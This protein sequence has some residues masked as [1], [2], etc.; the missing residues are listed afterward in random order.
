LGTQESEKADAQT[1]PYEEALMLYQH[2]SYVEAAAKL[3][4][5]LSKSGKGHAKATALLA[6]VYANQGKLG[7]ALQ[8][9]ETSIAADKLNPACHYLR[10]VILQE[11]GSIEE[12]TLS[13]N[14][15]YIWISVSCSL[16]LPWAISRRIKANSRNQRST[17]KM[18]SPY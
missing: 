11:Q 10:A 12:A 8:W 6:R 4:T 18:L 16:I 14:R 3:L 13:L 17:L 2:G 7:E 15:A 1:S 5:S 9:C